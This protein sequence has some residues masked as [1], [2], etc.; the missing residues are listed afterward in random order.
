[1]EQ[2]AADRLGPAD[3]VDSPSGEAMWASQAKLQLLELVERG[4]VSFD[5]DS[6]TGRGQWT[7]TDHG[8]RVEW[9][10]TGRLRIESM[11]KSQRT[12]LECLREL[13]EC[14]AAQEDHHRRHELETCEG[15]GDIIKILEPR[16]C[17]GMD[18]V[19]EFDPTAEHGM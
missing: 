18:R 2:N 16:T 8:R 14:L 5:P 9:C 19:V 1:M 13:K 17:Q 4:Q 3:Y 11:I 6:G 12:P 15:M 7:L 10:G